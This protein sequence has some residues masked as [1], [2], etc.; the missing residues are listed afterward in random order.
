MGNCCFTALTGK[1]ESGLIVDFRFLTVSVYA[2]E[3]SKQC[4]WVFVFP[5]YKHY[6]FLIISISM[7]KVHLTTKVKTNPLF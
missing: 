3:W 2:V 4:C 5:Y 1:P 7:Q 6:T